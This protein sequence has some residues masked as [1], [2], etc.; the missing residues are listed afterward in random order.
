MTRIFPLMA[1]SLCALTLSGCASL[2]QANCDQPNASNMRQCAP[3]L[4]RKDCEKT[5]WT[6]FGRVTGMAGRDL[7]QATRVKQCQDAGVAVDELSVR[8]GYEDG[9][10]LFC[11]EDRAEKRGLKGMELNMTPVCEEDARVKAEVAYARGLRVY[12]EPSNAFVIGSE[13]R[14]PGAKVCED[15]AWM[16]EY[17]KGRRVHLEA[18]LEARG[19]R[20]ADLNREYFDLEKRLLDLKAEQ[21]TVAGKDEAAKARLRQIELDKLEIDRKILGV[22][23]KQTALNLEMDR[24]KTEMTSL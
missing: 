10:T 17:R 11:S 14:D 16:A 18:K 13:G 20:E 9:V 7:K 2:L 19:E 23:E 5:N 4:V 21:L 12:C 1:A 8:K 15:E 22:R 24:I 3:Y 6:E